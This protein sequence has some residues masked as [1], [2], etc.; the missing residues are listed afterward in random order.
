MA[1]LESGECSGCRV[2][3]LWDLSWWTGA[4][5]APAVGVNDQQLYHMQAD[6]MS[7]I[8]NAKLAFR[9]ITE[10]VGWFSCVIRVVRTG[11]MES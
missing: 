11:E 2:P 3:R 10:A 5:Q 4:D 1:A 7:V 9:F 6:E 8:E